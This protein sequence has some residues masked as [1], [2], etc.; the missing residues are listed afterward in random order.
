MFC[1]MTCTPS[2][3]FNLLGLP[4]QFCDMCLLFWRHTSYLLEVQQIRHVDENNLPSAGTR[5]TA[6]T[7]CTDREQRDRMRG[8]SEHDCKRARPGG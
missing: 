4:L 1:S 3:S 2:L 6:E 8:Q 5:L 7:A